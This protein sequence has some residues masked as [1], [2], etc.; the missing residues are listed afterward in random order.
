MRRQGRDIEGAQADC[1]RSDLA[2]TTE[3]SM[4][5]ATQKIA[6]L[7]SRTAHVAQSVEHFLGKEEVSSSSLVMGST[8]V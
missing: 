3:Q 2:V 7:T 1:D 4:R 5:S 8:A 6:F